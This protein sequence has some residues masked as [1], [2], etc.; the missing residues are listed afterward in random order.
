METRTEAENAVAELDEKFAHVLEA[1]IRKQLVREAL[2][3]R[4]PAA[5]YALA[6]AILHRSPPARGSAVDLL[7]DALYSALIAR[8]DAGTDALPYGFRADL[9]R[10]AHEAEDEQVMRVLRS[11]TPME[12]ADDVALRLPKEV[13]D[14]P[15]GRRRSLAKGADKN[16]LDLLAL[17]CDPTVIANLLRNPKITEEDVVRLAARRPIAASSLLAV[18]ESPRWS[19]NPRVRVAL[20]RNPYAPVDVAI[21]VLGT[22]PLAD[23]RDMR[24]DPDLHPDTR[25]QVADE[26][27]RRGQSGLE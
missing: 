4:E 6:S 17:D 23:L 10:A 8:S 20:A 1:G 22:I 24:R 18:Y 11:S 26:L 19:R 21:Q 13:E 25:N 14:I 27:A 12:Q 15:L 16:L 9:Y 2:L 5:A 7:R 3:S